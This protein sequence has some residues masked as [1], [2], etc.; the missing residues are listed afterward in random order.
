MNESL[1]STLFFDAMKKCDISVFDVPGSY[2]QNDIPEDKLILLRII[3]EFLDIVCEVN[4]DYKPYVQYDSLKK[5]IYVRFWEQYM[6]ALSVLCYGKINNL[7]G[8]KYIIF[9]DTEP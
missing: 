5:L 8:P 7:V 2:L 1:I 9:I 4:P 6:D 3:Y